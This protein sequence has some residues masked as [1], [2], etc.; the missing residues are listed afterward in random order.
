VVNPEVLLAPLERE[1]IRLG[2]ADIGRLLDALGRPHEHRGQVLIAG[3]NGKGSTAALLASILEAAGH[4]TGLYTSPHLERVEE[5]VRIRGLAVRPGHLAAALERIVATARDLLGHPPT[6]FEA[7]TAAAFLLFAEADVEFELLEVGLG[8]RL[9]ATNLA[10]PELSLLTAIGLD[11]TEH[12]GRTTAAIAGEKAGILRPGAPGLGWVE[13]AQA[14]AAI[15]RRAAEIGAPWTAVDREVE[16][17]R[18]GWTWAGQWG[19]LDWGN[20]S[21]R[22]NTS[23]LG[24]H[25]GANLALAVR[26]AETLRDRSATHV[27][28]EAIADGIEACRWPGRLEPIAL[29]DGRRV[30]LDAAHNALGAERLAAFLVQAGSPYTMLFGVLEDKPGAR[31]LDTL[32]QNARRVVLT[33]PPSPRAMDPAALA[34]VACKPLVRVVEEPER[35]LE[36]ALAG[37]EE[38]VVACGSIYLLGRVRTLLRERFG[39]PPPAADVCVAG[40]SP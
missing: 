12:L 7:M 23:L 28:P 2:L 4:T 38:L 10:T 31:M 9:D 15:A 25:Q 22:V 6:Y 8:G 29:P 36:A 26:A 30:L 39:V 19:R 20:R 27:T 18:S 34:E 33:R 3:T 35:A 32:T 16:W 24:D 13:D 21:M 1:G 5:R 14:A 40:G 17:R 11:H 37:E